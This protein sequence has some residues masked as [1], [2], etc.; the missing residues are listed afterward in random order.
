MNAI[1]VSLAPVGD[2]IGD[3]PSSVQTPPPLSSASP[4]AGTLFPSFTTPAPTSVRRA[5]RG[6][7][8]SR[9]T[10]THAITRCG[11]IENE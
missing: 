3:S 8:A 11:D 10:A 4:R 5:T 6:T 1:T 9:T 2:G 7:S